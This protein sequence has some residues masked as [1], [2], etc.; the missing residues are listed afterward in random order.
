MSMFK[1]NFRSIRTG[2]KLSTESMKRIIRGELGLPET[3]APVPAAGK[4]LK[5]DGQMVVTTGNGRYAFVQ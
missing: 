1:S 2:A 3:P 4:T 5:V